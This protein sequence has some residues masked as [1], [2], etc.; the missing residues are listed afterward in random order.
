MNSLLFMFPFLLGVYAFVYM[1]L[2][3]LDLQSCEEKNIGVFHA[4][5]FFFSLS[6]I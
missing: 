1:C 4:S 2:L 3:Y 6:L 5:V